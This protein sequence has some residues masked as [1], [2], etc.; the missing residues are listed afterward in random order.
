[1]DTRIST[2]DGHFIDFEKEK[3]KEEAEIEEK[4][5]IRRKKKKKAKIEYQMYNLSITELQEIFKKA[6]KNRNGELNEKEF[7]EGFKNYGGKERSEGELLALFNRIDANSNSSIDWCEFYSFIFLERQGKRKMKENLNAKEFIPIQTKDQNHFS[8]LHDDVVNRIVFD[9]IFNEYYTLSQSCV[10]NWNAKNFKFNFDVHESKAPLIDC[11]LFPN[12][13]LLFTLNLNKTIHSFNTKT[14][15]CNVIFKGKKS[16]FGK[17][18]D[19]EMLSSGK[20]SR[21]KKSTTFKNKKKKKRKKIQKVTKKIP[22]VILENLFENTTSFSVFNFGSN[23]ASSSIPYSSTEETQTSIQMHNPNTSDMLAVGLQNGMIKLYDIS[24]KKE[25][26]FSENSYTPLKPI[27]VLDKKSQFDGWVTSFAVL[28]TYKSIFASS[29]DG[30]LKL[31]RGDTLFPVRSYNYKKTGN[32]PIHRIA[33]SNQLNVLA[34]CGGIKEIQL[35]NPMIKSHIARLHDLRHS[36]IDVTFCEDDNLLIGLTQNKVIK[37]YDVRTFKCLQTLKVKQKG[38]IQS[39]IGGGNNY[40]AIVYNQKRNEIITA[41]NKLH[42]FSMRKN[43]TEFDMNSYSGTIYPVKGVL[44]STITKYVVTADKKNI[45]TWKLKNGRIQYKFPI[46][47]KISWI[48]WDDTERRILVCVGNN[49]IRAYNYLNG[50]LLKVFEN[51]TGSELTCCCYVKNA[52]QRFRFLGVGGW[53]KRVLTYL[54]SSD[55]EHTKEE[56]QKKYPKLKSDIL[57]M[58]SCSNISIVCAHLDGSLTLIDALGTVRMVS[59][60]EKKKKYKLDAKGNVKLIKN[61]GSQTDS[62]AYNP[63]QIEKLIWMKNKPK[64]FLSLRGNGKISFWYHSNLQ[65]VFDLDTLTNRNSGYENEEDRDGDELS[66]IAL[67]RSNTVFLTGSK[68][69]YITLYDFSKFIDALFVD[70]DG[71][72][73][74]KFVKRFKAHEKKVTNLIYVDEFKVIVSGSRDRTSSVFTEKGERIGIIGQKKRW[75]LHDKETWNSSSFIDLLK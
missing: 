55:D 24:R 72:N 33:F 38:S 49:E 50:Q 34:A 22:V 36:I 43:F 23:H 59:T 15:T 8:E 27:A 29:L 75:K 17:K 69:G 11:N 37:I 28:N 56:I 42:S 20:F 7:V 57:S 35:F 32:K 65:H 60:I 66:C 74:I 46:G 26:E 2:I 63:L 61:Q 51:P 5:R 18:S 3:K 39:S 25:N 68:K 70:S 62:L 1:M 13:H 67:S 6:D 71:Y 45:Y 40:S 16:A 4:K 12:R 58:I 64:M 10:K 21:K 52:I 53:E 48:K 31:F 14:G 73:L 47:K 54:D 44:F 41:S 9:P 30:N 19:F